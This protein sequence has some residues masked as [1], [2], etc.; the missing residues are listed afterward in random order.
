MKREPRP[1]GNSKTMVRAFEKG[2]V[3]AGHGNFLD[4]L[5]LK[6]MGVFTAYGA[7]NGS[8]Q[9]LKELKNFGASL[10]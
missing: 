1:N 6:N 10:Q 2:A 8:P 3:S 5:G 7:I 4:Y 9:K